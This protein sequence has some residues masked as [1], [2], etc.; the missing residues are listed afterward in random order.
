MGMV[1]DKVVKE[2]PVAFEQ[3]KN[4]VKNLPALLSKDEV[5][6]VQGS[7][8]LRMNFGEQHAV[9]LGLCSRCNQ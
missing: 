2:Q 4:G 1:T 7:P 9:E 8:Q 6:R 3:F 5:Q